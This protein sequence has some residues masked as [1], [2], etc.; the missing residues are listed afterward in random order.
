MEMLRTMVVDDEYIVREHFERRIPWEASGFTWLGAAQNGREAIEMMEKELPHIVLTDITMPVM[1]GLEFAKYVRDRWPK[2]RVIFLTAHDEFAYAQKALVLG[3]KNYL[4]KMGLSKEQIIQACQQVAEEIRQEWNEEER[5][6]IRT[7]QHEEEE[8]ALKHHIIHRLL[9]GTG[10]STAESMRFLNEMLD[11]NGRDFAVVSV[12]WD[13]YS[14]INPLNNGPFS[15]EGELQKMQWQAGK[16]LEQWEE[17]SRSSGIQ[18]VVFPYKRCRLSVVLTCPSHRG[19][20]FF[21]TKLNEF[22]HW[23]LSTVRESLGT[24]CFLYAG[25]ITSQRERLPGMLRE[26]QHKLLD[27]F[28]SGQ[29]VILG[30]DGSSYLNPE[31]MKRLE[32]AAKLSQS[33]LTRDWPSFMEGVKTLTQ[34]QNPPYSPQFLLGVAEAVLDNGMEG[35]EAADLDKLRLRL[36]LIVTWEQYGQWWE[37]IAQQM[38]VLPESR[39]ENKRIRKEIQKICQLVSDQYGENWSIANLAEAVQMNPAY[40]GQLF[41]QETGEYLTDYIS[42]VRLHK[43]KELLERTDMKIYEVAQKVGITDYRYFCKMF[44][45]TIGVTPTE[46]KKSI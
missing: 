36:D 12:A 11:W 28:Y 27:Y 15:E 20:A 23:A 18:A 41:K 29:S 32:L 4:L 3:A 30:Q 37:R 10:G 19:Y 14:L 17:L 24:E 26:G 9:E 44:K 31:K 2:V 8:R 6:R 13:G 5:S 38:A 35:T 40:V 33:L 43:A 7:E 21:Q 42:R 45:S 34:R 39:R 22:I 1:D 16:A 25:Q 46:Y